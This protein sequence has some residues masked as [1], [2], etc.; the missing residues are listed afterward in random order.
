MYTTLKPGRYKLYIEIDDNRLQDEFEATFSYYFDTLEVKE[1]KSWEV[2]YGKHYPKFL[3]AVL[4]N[5]AIRLNNEKVKIGP[6][7]NDWIATNF[8][9]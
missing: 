6:K 5:H 9:Y 7:Q 3:E 2:E 1:N 4:T 8:M